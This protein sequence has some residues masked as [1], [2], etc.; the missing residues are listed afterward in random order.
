MAWGYD[1][2]VAKP[3]VS[4]RITSPHNAKVKLATSLA[5]RKE[6]ERF[7]LVLVE[8]ERLMDQALEFGGQFSF[9]FVDRQRCSSALWHRLQQTEA[10][11]FEVSAAIIE[12]VA[13]TTS[14]QG[15]I[16]VAKAVDEQAVD[17]DRATF[18]VVADGLQDPG[19]LGTIQRV[20]T[21]VGV[22]GLVL[23][24]G[25]VDP[26]HP[27]AVR[28]SAGAYFK[29]ALSTGWDASELSRRLADS[30]FRTVVADASG[31]KDLFSYD[32][33]GRVALVIG[34]EAQGPSQALAA[35]DRVS[36]PMPGGGESLNAGV[37]AGILLYTAWNARRS[38]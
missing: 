31:T 17:F 1:R 36:I 35:S 5:R 30:G 23:T 14:P 27:R 24:H 9:V 15:V 20:A 26:K 7:G 28:A 34:S 6:R 2:S 3:E 22:D 4:L 8:G 19:N 16:G 10:E 32:W 13:T 33:S 37:A 21:A 18:L 38:Q 29:L 11:L 25:S 12:K